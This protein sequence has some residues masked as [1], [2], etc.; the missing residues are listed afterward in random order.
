M[1]NSA[2][3]SQKVSQFQFPTEEAVLFNSEVRDLILKYLGTSHHDNKNRN[4]PSEIL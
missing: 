3:N 1:A 2:G 4:F